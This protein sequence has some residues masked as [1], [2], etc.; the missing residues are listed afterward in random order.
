MTVRARL[1][2]HMLPIACLALLGVLAG[3]AGQLTDDEP[4]VRGSGPWRGQIVD[5]ETGQPLEGVV[6][7]AY[8]TRSEASLGGWAATE[9][10]ASEEVATG[11]DGRFVIQSRRSYTIPAVIRVAGPEFRIFKPGYGRWVLRGDVSA[12]NRGEL[13]VVE[14]PPLRSREE[15]LLLYQS[16][17]F[18]PS[19][20]VPLDRQRLFR[21]AEDIERRFL[22]LN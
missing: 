21:E 5:A 22:G 2:Q 19:G 15:R 12:F 13:V 10:C 7:L 4:A 3:C 11:P 18:H 6:V 1:S 9:Y 17:G 14:L 8:W 20:A 16:P